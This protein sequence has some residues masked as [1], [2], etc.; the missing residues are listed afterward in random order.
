MKILTAARRF[1][2]IGGVSKFNT[3][4]TSSTEQTVLQR[5]YLKKQLE[6]SKSGG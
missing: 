2:I 1:I 6:N 4:W 3:T 5:E